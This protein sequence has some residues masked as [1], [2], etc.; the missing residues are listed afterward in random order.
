LLPERTAVDTFTEW[1][2][3]AEPHLR[4]A[5]TAL[6]GVDDGL[7]IASEALTLAWERWSEVAVMENSTGYVYTAAR[8]IGRRRHRH[9]R[10]R[11]V[12]MPVPVDR[13]PWVEP[14]L[15]KALAGLSEQQRL[16]VTLLHG[17]Q[18]SMSEVAEVLGLSKST[19]QNHAERGLT[20]LQKRLGV[21]R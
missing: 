3:D 8:N 7:E 16:V 19:I 6:F 1:A 13:L 17:Y 5:L 2:R 12:Y 10:H 4:E 15:P 21:E 9:R 20:R 14:G 11:P 18:W